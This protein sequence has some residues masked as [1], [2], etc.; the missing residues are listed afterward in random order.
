[1]K[2]LVT[3]AAGMLGSDVVD[4][5]AERGHEVVALARA[6][7]DVTDAAAVEAAI[8]RHRPDAV[9][10]CAA[11]TDVDGTEDAE[12]AAMRVNDTGA[13][14]VA[15]AA[16][17]IGAKVLY[18]SSDY[19][20]DG[21]K[22]RPYVESD[23]PAALSAYGRTK[24]AGETSVAVA[25]PRHF[26]VRSS[27]LFGT[28]GQNFVETMLR[29]GSEQPEVLVVSDQHGCPTYTRH[30]AEGLALLVEGDEFGIHHL[31]GAGSCSWFDFAQEIFDQAGLESRVMAATTDMLA[32][33]APRPANSVLASERPDPIVLPHWKQGLG[34]Y[35]AERQVR[36]GAA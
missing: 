36:A 10:N 22:R 31:A 9:V 23:L 28:N 16:A 3:G 26:V 11:W 6:D 20:F 21:S 13:A 17:A 30:L 19:V 4:A 24:Q 2:T 8:D 7:L 27:W 25:N 33:K 34:E 32:R 12:S 35:M 18:V 29:L 1:M 5:C 14:L 15:T